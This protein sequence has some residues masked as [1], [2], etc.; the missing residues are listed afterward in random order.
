MPA[1]AGMSDLLLASSQQLLIKIWQATNDGCLG[2]L[3]FAPAKPDTAVFFGFEEYLVS[4]ALMALAWTTADVRYRFRIRTA[5][6]PMDRLTF[7]VVGAIGILTLLT[8]L[9]R[10]QAWPVLVGPLPP[11]VWQAVLGGALLLTFLIWAWLAF[12]RPSTYGRLNAKRYAET[13]YRVILRGSP[14]ELAIAADELS[15]S[16]EAL[17]RH[18]STRPTGQP[19]TQDEP[20]PVTGSAYDILLLIADE[21]LCR[22]MVDS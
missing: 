8:D 5:P 15:R 1:G 10:A 22:A 19:G 16:A 20:P 13:L 18:A 17:V 4:L 11:A 3:C 21:R 2:R 9:W 14:P 6:L 7:W 12:I